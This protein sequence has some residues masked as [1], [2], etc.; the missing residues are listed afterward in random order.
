MDI[1]NSTPEEVKTRKMVRR[2]CEIYIQGMRKLLKLTPPKESPCS[3]CAFAPRTDTW[4]GFES[5]IWGM[6]QATEKGLPF[7]CHRNLETVDGDY[8]RHEDLSKMIPCAGYEAVR[9]SPELR[10]VLEDAAIGSELTG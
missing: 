6:I 5:T 4:D 3:T 2:F 9:H 8:K 10:R 1:R 7:Y